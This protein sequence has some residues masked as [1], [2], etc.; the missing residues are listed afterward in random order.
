MSGTDKQGQ[1]F[2]MES[3]TPE[4]KDG[5]ETSSGGMKVVLEATIAYDTAIV[6]TY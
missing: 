6:L 1:I 2:N 5:S 4:L 3:E